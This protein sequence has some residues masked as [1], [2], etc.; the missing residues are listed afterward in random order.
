[1]LSQ[2]PE[3][4]IVVVRQPRSSKT[5]NDANSYLTVNS[6][7]INFLNSQGMLSNCNKN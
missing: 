1:M 4:I 7:S 5:Y 3:Q 2:I 6:C